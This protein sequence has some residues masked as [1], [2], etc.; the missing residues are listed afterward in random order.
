MKGYYQNGRAEGEFKRWDEDGSQLGTFYYSAG[1]R[2][3][4]EFALHKKIIL[5]NVKRKLYSSRRFSGLND[6]L[7]SD[8]CGTVHHFIFP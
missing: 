2:I 6:H 3:D 7:I 1:V 5:L 8:L 4:L